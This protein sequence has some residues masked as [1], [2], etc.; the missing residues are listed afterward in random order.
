MVSYCEI[1]TLDQVWYLIVSIPDLCTL[2]YFDLQ[3]V[4][5]VFSGHTHFLILIYFFTTQIN[6]VNNSVHLIVIL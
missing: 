1:G 6:F 2:T 3:C 4:I 5:V